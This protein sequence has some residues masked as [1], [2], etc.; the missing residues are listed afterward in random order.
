MIKLRDSLTEHQ[1]LDAFN[2]AVKATLG[3]KDS[4]L[5]TYLQGPLLAACVQQEQ[6]LGVDLVRT[7]EGEYGIQYTG[8]S[9]LE[10]QRKDRQIH[11]ALQE[12]GYACP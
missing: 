7:Y 3:W 10:C 1:R 2:L 4:E 6:A 12:A 8:P 5:I 11:R 9:T